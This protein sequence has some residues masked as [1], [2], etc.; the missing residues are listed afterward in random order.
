MAKD[1]STTKRYYLARRF[2]DN[3][4]TESLETRS[5]IVDAYVAG[6]EEAIEKSAGLIEDFHN[7]VITPIARLIRGIDEAQVDAYGERLHKD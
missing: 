2:A 1:F 5:K 6:Y 3:V 4:R 7:P